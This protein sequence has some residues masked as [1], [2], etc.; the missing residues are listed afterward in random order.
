MVHSNNAARIRLW[1]NLKEGMQDEIDVKMVTYP[2]LKSPE[3]AAVNPLKKVPGF[4]R[5]DG[6]TV[7]ESAVILNYLED[8]HSCA[9]PSFK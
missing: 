2:D 7:F 8:K 6:V 3:F 9:M 4:I 5:T 1:R